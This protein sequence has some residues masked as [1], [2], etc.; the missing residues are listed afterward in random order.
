M[1]VWNNGG[2]RE[3]RDYMVSQEIAPIAVDPIPPDFVKSAEALGVA[4]RDKVRLSCCLSRLLRE[5]TNHLNKIIYIP[6]N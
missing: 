5:G 1:I 6:G 3:I 4:L 2:Y